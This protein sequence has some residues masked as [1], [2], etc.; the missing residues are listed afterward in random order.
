MRKNDD[1]KENKSGCGLTRRTMLKATLGLGTLASMGGFV[2]YASGSGT[3][4]N[5]PSGGY[6]GKKANWYNGFIFQDENLVFELIRVMA[7]TLEHGADI[8]ES[9]STAFR[10]KQKEGDMQALLHA[11]SSFQA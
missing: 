8:G 9:L 4:A 11:W 5:S 3:P 6:V 2:A 7:K 1:M 10:I